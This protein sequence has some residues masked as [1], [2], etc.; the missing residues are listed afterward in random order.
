MTAIKNALK[1]YID[2]TGSEKEEKKGVLAKAI[3]GF[4]ENYFKKADHPF[5]LQKI[6]FEIDD[7]IED[8]GVGVTFDDYGTM[9]KRRK[10][11]EEEINKLDDRLFSHT[12][13]IIENAAKWVRCDTDADEL[14]NAFNIARDYFYKVPNGDKL[15]SK[16]RDMF[17]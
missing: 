3:S 1:D 5:D 16:F 4:Q 9:A 6:T 8:Y 15:E 17:S 14:E 10:E 7:I 12:K 13:T 11:N 2:A